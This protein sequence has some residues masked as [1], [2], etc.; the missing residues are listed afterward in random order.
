[1]TD[2]DKPYSEAAEATAVCYS[3]VADFMTMQWHS[4]C[5]EGTYAAPESCQHTL[6]TVS[7][8]ELSPQLQHLSG[9]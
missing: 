1:M 2:S 7:P 3:C 5:I 8:W 6:M 4:A 9:C